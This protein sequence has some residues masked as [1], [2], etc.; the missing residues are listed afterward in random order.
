[1][2]S[3]S[4]PEI[5]FLGV[6]RSDARSARCA[7]YDLPLIFRM[8]APSTIRSMNAVASGGSPRYSPHLSK[9]T[10]VTSAVERSPRALISFHHQLA[11]CG[12]SSRSTRSNPNSSRITRSKL[13]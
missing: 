1:M 11:A 3:D 12:D 10:F 6:L 13:A 2:L 9:S 8:A 7:R 4:L 5:H